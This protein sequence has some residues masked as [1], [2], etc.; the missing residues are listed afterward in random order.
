ME[1][2]RF[3]RRGGHIANF[4]PSMTETFVLLFSSPD[5][6]QFLLDTPFHRHRIPYIYVNV[7]LRCVLFFFSLLLFCSLSFV[8]AS[9]PINP[10]FFLPIV[11]GDVG[12]P[13]SVDNHV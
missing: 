13:P 8:L 1:N 11:D 6:F 9:L 12:V 10:F 4:L 2:G 3:R 5:L 7:A